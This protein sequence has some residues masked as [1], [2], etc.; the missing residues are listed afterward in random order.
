MSWWD[1]KASTKHRSCDGGGGEISGDTTT[2]TTQTHRISLGQ[3]HDASHCARDHLCY[4]I[5][6]DTATGLVM[7]PV[8]FF[9]GGMR[10]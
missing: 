6:G 9:I 1:P 10:L 3:Q 7:V 8:Q 2:K 4:Q 5:V